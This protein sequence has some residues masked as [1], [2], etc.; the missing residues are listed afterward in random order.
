M[1]KII[2]VTVGTTMN[3]EKIKGSGGNSVHF[4]E[5]EPTDAKTGDFWYDESEGES[6]VGSG[7]VQ[8]DWNQNDPS[9]PD[10]VKNRPFW[11]DDPVETVFF[12]GTIESDADLE[13]ELTNGQEYTVVLDGVEYILTASELDGYVV[14]GSE[15][16]DLVSV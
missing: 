16:S 2:G 4:G 1:S 7:S 11:T 14:L 13:F 9:A 5:E 8:A 6:G 3:P 15:R 10:Y 12:D